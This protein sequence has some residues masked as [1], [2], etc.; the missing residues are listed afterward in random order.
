MADW[1]AR[2]AKANPNAAAGLP[3]QYSIRAYADAYVIAEALRQAGANLAP[4]N[5]VAQL[6]TI[7]DFIAGK[8]DAFKYATAIGLPRSFSPSNHQGTKVLTPVVVQD[9]R[10]VTAPRS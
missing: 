9:G 7:Q 6:D 10:F 4:E 1:R 3:N 2:F 5:V 8:D